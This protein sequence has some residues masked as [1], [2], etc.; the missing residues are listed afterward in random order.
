MRTDRQTDITKLIC[1]FRNFENAP[2][3]NTV[4]YNCAFIV[5][6]NDS[7]RN[8]HKAYG[9]LIPITVATDYN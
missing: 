9:R 2:N 6:R 8:A 1:A 4:Y 7:L 5:F 3:M